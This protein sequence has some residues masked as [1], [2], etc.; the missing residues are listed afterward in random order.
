MSEEQTRTETLARKHGR[1]P[2]PTGQ[3]PPGN[4]LGRSDKLTLAG[5]AVFVVALILAARYVPGIRM[6]EEVTDREPV[7]AAEPY[8]PAYMKVAPSANLSLWTYSEEVDPLTDKVTRWACVKSTNQVE[9]EP[10]YENVQAQLCVRHDPRHG[11]DVYVRLL[12]DGQLLYRSYRPGQVTVRFDDKPAS[13]WTA[14]GSSDGSSNIAFLT[15]PAKFE[16]AMTAAKTTLIEAEFYEAGAQV[17]R[18]P[19]HDFAW[20]AESKPSP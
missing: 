20:P 14:V 11:R 1:E 2:L 16:A 15:S 12:G 4:S 7:A 9:L 13:K 8:K 17:M 6:P 3:P 10:P 5:A 19:T 18:F